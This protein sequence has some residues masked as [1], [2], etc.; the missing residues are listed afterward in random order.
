MCIL[1][2]HVQ[3]AHRFFEILP[4]QVEGAELT[5]ED[6]VSHILLDLF[7]KGAVDEV[8]IR[9]PTGLSHCSIHIQALCFCQSF[10]LLPRTEEN[11]KHALVESASSLLKE[12]FGPVNIESVTLRPFPWNY[13]HDENNENQ[14]MCCHQSAC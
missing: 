4:D 6:A 11:M 9:F 7:G 12:L 14:A 1:L 8:T 10:T 5:V 2:M 13:E 3:C